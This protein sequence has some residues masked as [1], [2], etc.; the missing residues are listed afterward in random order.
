MSHLTYN[1]DV[2]LVLLIL[3]SLGIYIEFLRPGWI[4]PAVGGS[5]LFLVAA[6]FFDPPGWAAATVLLAAFLLL[7]LGA[8][9]PAGYLLHAAAAVAMPCGVMLL[10]PRVHWLTALLVVV[11]FTLLTSSLL[12]LAVRARR[13]K[14][15]SFQPRDIL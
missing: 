9:C 4:V 10:E 3:G 2:A 14:M 13:N 11:P 12:R 15:G 1:P 7:L 5:V 6:A 8:F